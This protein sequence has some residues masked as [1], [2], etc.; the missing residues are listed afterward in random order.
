IMS[1]GV[2]VMMLLYGGWLVWVVMGFTVIYVVLRLSTYR[3]YRQASEEQLVKGAKAGS[4]FM[5]TL[6]G[7][8]T[9]KALGLAGTRSQYWLNLNIDTTNANIRL[10]KLDMMFGGV[11]SLI[12]TCDQIV[13]LWL[14]ASLVI[15][16]QMT[17]GMFVAFNAYR[18]Q[19][20]DR[21]SNLIDMVL[22][23][24]MLSLHNERVADIVLSEP[25]KQMPP[26]QLY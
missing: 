25:E 4:H 22:R 26:R 15:D 5:E 21:A 18:G 13:I 8:G 12:S 19:F 1:I 16:N 3:H 10:T 17:L 14:G 2:F 6:Y 7:I 11:N 24:R 23:L 20:S 9:L